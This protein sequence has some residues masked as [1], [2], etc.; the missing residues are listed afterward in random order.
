M[1]YQTVDLAQ[2]ERKNSNFIY[3]LDTLIFHS[4]EQYDLENN[5]LKKIK[6]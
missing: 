5:V 4:G 3:K 6:N 1:E 2:R